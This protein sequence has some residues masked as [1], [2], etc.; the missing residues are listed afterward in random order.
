MSTKSHIHKIYEILKKTSFCTK[1]YA[2]IYI[3]R[4]FLNNKKGIL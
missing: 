2:K 4:P 3:Q 1:V